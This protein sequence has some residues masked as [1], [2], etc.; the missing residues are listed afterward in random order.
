MQ[1]K[2]GVTLSLSCP[3]RNLIVGL[4]CAILVVRRTKQ[5]G[6]RLWSKNRKHT[7]GMGA[8]V[9]DRLLFLPPPAN[10]ASSRTR[11]L[12]RRIFIGAHMDCVPPGYRGADGSDTVI[13]LPHFHDSS[14]LCRRQVVTPVSFRC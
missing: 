13:T 3:L 12:T 2:V 1:G 6:V 10:D 4:K 11:P 9:R 8:G 5:I 14:R 7:D